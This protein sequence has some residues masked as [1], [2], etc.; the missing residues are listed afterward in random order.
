V[1]PGQ[2]EQ[3]VVLVYNN[4]TG[5]YEAQLNVTV[6]NNE[7]YQYITYKWYKANNNEE[8]LSQDNE[9]KISFEKSYNIETNKNL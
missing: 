7:K 5:A 6:N 1:I 8:I 3:Q 2:D 9:Y 4:E